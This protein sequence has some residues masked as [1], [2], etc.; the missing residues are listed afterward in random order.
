MLL[1]VEPVGAPNS[2]A[3]ICFAPSPFADMTLRALGEVC[4]ICDHALQM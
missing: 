4:D 1:L 2:V 3:Q